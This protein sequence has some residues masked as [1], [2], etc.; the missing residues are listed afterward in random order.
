M[1]VKKII[2]VILVGILFI[3]TIVFAIMNNNKDENKKIDIQK[4][5]EELISA[6]IFEDNLSKIDKE[7]A[8]KRYNFNAET[9]KDICSYIGTG[10]T[11]EEILIIELNNKTD[12][13]TTKEI[14]TTE[15]EDRK[16]NYQN[17]LPKEVSKLE[18][19]NLEMLGNYIILCISNDYDTAK[20]IID[21]NTNT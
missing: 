3:I 11:A 7:S 14:I 13:E 6:P 12:R 20:E 18:N 19:Y 5:A 9:I 15:I 4:L 17:Y 16:V 2:A 1:N 10:A 8:M 21:K